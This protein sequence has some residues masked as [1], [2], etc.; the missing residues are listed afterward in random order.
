MLTA[1]K[2]QLPHLQS[3]SKQFEIDEDDL[4]LLAIKSAFREWFLDSLPCLDKRLE[5]EGDASVFYSHVGRK[6]NTLISF[7]HL[8]IRH[9]EEERKWNLYEESRSIMDACD[10]YDR[11][12]P[13]LDAGLSLLL[14]NVLKSEN[15]QAAAKR[16]LEDLRELCSMELKE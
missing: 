7:L 2:I 14:D 12:V 4:L 16:V 15:R 5:W 10:L 8:A 13:G 3:L 6:V 1:I 9:M 11:S